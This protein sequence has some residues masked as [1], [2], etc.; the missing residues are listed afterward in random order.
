MHNLL[1]HIDL[2]EGEYDVE[3]C[4]LGIQKRTTRQNSREELNVSK[5]QLARADKILSTKQKS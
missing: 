5:N 4:L 1:Y 2:K 3:S